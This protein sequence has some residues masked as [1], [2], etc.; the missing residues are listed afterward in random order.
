MVHRT[1][2]KLSRSAVPV[3]LVAVPPVVEPLAEL[4]VCPVAVLV[5]EVAVA[6]VVLLLRALRATFPFLVSLAIRSATA[7]L[8]DKW[9]LAMIP[10]PVSAE[11][12][13]EFLA[14]PAVLVRAVLVHPTQLRLL[15]STPVGST[16]DLLHDTHSFSTNITRS[17]R[18]K[19]SA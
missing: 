4:L 9:H 19:P 1:R 3:Q 2:L 16:T 7:Q 5:D 18:S 15:F 13:L 6:A 11:C 14:R 12:L 10:L 8:L 17:F